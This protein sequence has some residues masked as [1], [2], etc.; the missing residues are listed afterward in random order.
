MSISISQFILPILSPLGVHMFVL[1]IC[2]YFCPVA[3]GWQGRRHLSCT[4]TH[5]RVPFAAPGLARL[6]G[7]G[8]K[9]PASELLPP[10]RPALLGELRTC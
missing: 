4:H 7:T 6:A 9:V 2:V 3:T 10:G 5:P 1:Y 8:Q